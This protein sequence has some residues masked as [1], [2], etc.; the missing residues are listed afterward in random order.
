MFQG[1]SY[2]IEIEFLLDGKS[3]YKEKN[4]S[5]PWKQETELI[6]YSIN[7]DPQNGNCD[8]KKVDINLKI[9]T[10]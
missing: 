7:Y 9:I 1:E 2:S 4:M 5:L 6:E 3:I 8:T 10:K